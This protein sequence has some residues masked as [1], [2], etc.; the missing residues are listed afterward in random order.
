MKILLA[1]DSFKGSLSASAFCELVATALHALDSGIEVIKLP[2]SDGGEGLA[3]I[4]ALQGSPCRE[5]ISF[6]LDKRLLYRVE[7]E[8]GENYRIRVSP[9]GEVGVRKHQRKQ[10]TQQSGSSK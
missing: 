7:C 3:E 5:V 9:E 2:M 4:L 10:D 8:S 1:P 6:Y